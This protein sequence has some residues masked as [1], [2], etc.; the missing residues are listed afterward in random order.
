MKPYHETIVRT[1]LPEHKKSYTNLDEALKDFIK[2]AKRFI[3]R[4][5]NKIVD[6]FKNVAEHLIIYNPEIKTKL[7]Q[8]INYAKEHNFEVEIEA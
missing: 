1:I 8:L 5:E 2:R 6:P 4:R 3:K 7:L